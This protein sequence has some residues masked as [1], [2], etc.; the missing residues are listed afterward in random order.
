MEK[1]ASK[2]GSKAC[3]SPFF[4]TKTQHIL[5]ASVACRIRADRAN[6]QSEAAVYLQVIIDSK[7]TTVPLHVTWPLDH[8]DNKK[9]IFLQRKKIDQLAHDYNLLA[10]KEIAKI[11]DIFMFY[12][13]SDMTLT[14]EVFHKEYRRYGGKKDF[15]IWAENDINDRY[16]EHK[17]A[18]QTY[19]NEISGI[20]KLKKFKNEIPFSIITKEFLETLE[21]WLVHKEGMAVSSAWRILK[22]LTTY[23]RRAYQA[24]IS[25]NMESVSQYTMP[26]FKG[27]KVYLKPSEITK[28]KDYYN[29]I[30]IPSHHYRILGHFLFACLTGLRF[31]DIQR[32]SW[33]NIDD[34]VMILVPYKTR[35]MMKTIKIPIGE[36]HY[37]LI[38]NEKGLLFNTI[39]EQK[40]N[41]ALKDIASAAG[42]R[43]NLTTHVARHTFA[44][45]FL[46]RGGHIEVLQQLMGHEKITTTLEYT[47]VDDDRLKDQMQLMNRL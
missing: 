31:S 38:H 28:L 10:T 41:K 46:R 16:A 1:Y 21:G 2:A 15:L 33:S 9:G 29:S 30:E 4:H 36:Q 6:K 12:R 42:I 11:N 20:N 14:I 45:E 44:T 7:R 26:K 5:R 32:V 39:T 23:L 40:T 27:R 24:G 13:H 25:I 22:T 3:F 8:F 34:D 17:I 35:R 37:E 18:K 47:H 43:K 19:K